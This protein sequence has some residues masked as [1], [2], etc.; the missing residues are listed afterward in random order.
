VQISQGRLHEAEATCRA[1]IALAAGVRLGPLGLAWILLGAIALE[2]NDLAEAERWLPA[3]IALARQGGMM[4]DM[5]LGLMH[6]A[7]L[8]AA[9]GETTA[10]LAA[11]QEATHY[12]EE[13]GDAHLAH[14]ALRCAALRARA[15]GGRR[16]AA[17]SPAL[18]ERPP[19]H[20]AGQ[21]TRGARRVYGVYTGARAA[22][23]W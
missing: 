5:V 3:G 21:S 22:G 16:R 12:T 19:G 9:Q 13:R 17:G 15:A 11:L 6:L 14:L 8:R 4:E 7:R 23:D 1:A 2:R 18:G 20:P 10:A